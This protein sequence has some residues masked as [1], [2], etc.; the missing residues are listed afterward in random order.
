MVTTNLKSRIFFELFQVRHLGGFLLTALLEVDK[1]SNGLT[2]E[3]AF[4]VGAFFIME[5]KVWKIVADKIP[6]SSATLILSK[7]SIFSS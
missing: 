7:V 3:S 6:F 2:S 1:A 4:P 5:D